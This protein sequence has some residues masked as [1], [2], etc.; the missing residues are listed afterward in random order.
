VEKNQLFQK[1]RHLLNTVTSKE[2]KDNKWFAVFHP[3]K[4]LF[5]L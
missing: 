4:I 2:R 1:L 5:L 3:L